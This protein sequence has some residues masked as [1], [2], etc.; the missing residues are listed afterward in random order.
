VTACAGCREPWD[1]DD[2]DVEGDGVVVLAVADDVV[3][4]PE[5]PV[6]VEAELPVEVPVRPEVPVEVA[7]AVWAG[8]SWAATPTSTPVPNTAEATTQRLVRRTRSTAS[9]R[10]S[11]SNRRGAADAGAIR[12]SPSFTIR[13]LP[14]RLK[15]LPMDPKN[16]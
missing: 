9:S 11:V 16:R 7:A 12:G 5:E 4:P 6:P 15:I 8:S 1:T 13:S 14:V 2:P 3:E 10:W